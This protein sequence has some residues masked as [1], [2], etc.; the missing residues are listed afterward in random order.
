VIRLWIRYVARRTERQMQRQA[1]ATATIQT[2]VIRLEMLAREA[3]A[4]YLD[5][6]GRAMQEPSD[7]ELNATMERCYESYCNTLAMYRETCIGLGREPKQIGV[8]V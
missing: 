5:M 6:L 2:S 3:W 8:V 4:T 7:P 1:E